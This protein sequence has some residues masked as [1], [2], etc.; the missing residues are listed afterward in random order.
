MGEMLVV[1][2][3]DADGGS[4]SDDGGVWVEML[5]VVVVAGRQRC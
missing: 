3:G 2:G 1:F 4:G 5:M